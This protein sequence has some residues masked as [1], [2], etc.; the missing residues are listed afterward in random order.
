MRR[1]PSTFYTAS[2]MESDAIGKLLLQNIITYPMQCY[3]ILDLEIIVIPINII[4]ESNSFVL[5]QC[6]L[7]IL[8]YSHIVKLTFLHSLSILC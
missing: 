5:K 4:Y 1:L 2:L 6:S 8:S 7:Y 3:K